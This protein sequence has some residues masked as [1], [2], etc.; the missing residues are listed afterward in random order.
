MK[1]VLLIVPAVLLSLALGGC[2]GG[3]AAPPASA[4]AA[5][6]SATVATVG[7]LSEEGQDL[8]NSRPTVSFDG[9]M[10]R[11]RVVIAVE[12]A[13]DA[14]LAG[15]R[16]DLESA[17]AAAGSTLESISPDVLEPALLQKMVPELIVALPAGATVDQG[18]AIVTKATEEAGEAKAGVD[19][20]YVLPVLVHDLRFTA[21]TE[22][23]TALSAAV[24]LEG[25]VSDALG[26]YSTTVEDGRLSIDY[27]GPLLGDETVESVRA[28]IARQAHTAVSAAV[29]PRSSAGEGVDMAT[30]PA[31]DPEQL[32]SPQEHPHPAG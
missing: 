12:S 4:G 20:F 3:P 2:T 8:G 13:N 29:G 28:G 22:D 5:S 18:R 21:D 16:T 11:R 7:T 32:V 26:N 30:E 10:V 6:E 27:T 24:D 14:D 9:L 25:I 23:P 15:V 31:W 17:A 1:R 19:N